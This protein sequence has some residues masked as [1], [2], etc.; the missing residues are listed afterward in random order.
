MLLY[1]GIENITSQDHEKSRENFRN[2]QNP[3]LI[4]NFRSSI[5]NFI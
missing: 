3:L 1:K 2:Y 5:N 4:K